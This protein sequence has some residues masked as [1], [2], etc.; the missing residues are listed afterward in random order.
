M[1]ATPGVRHGQAWSAASCTCRRNFASLGTFALMSSPT[2]G[3]NPSGA[4]SEEAAG[5]WIS[6]ARR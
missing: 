2:P 4:T 1:V 6:G 5:L 3:G